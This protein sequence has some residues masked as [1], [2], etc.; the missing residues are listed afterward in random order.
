LN[1]KRIKIFKNSNYKPPQ[2][3]EQQFE[4]LQRIFHGKKNGINSPNFDLFVGTK[5]LEFKPN[6]CKDYPKK[7][8]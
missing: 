3:G 5:C 6:E 2:L 1:I 8:R 4:P 7:M